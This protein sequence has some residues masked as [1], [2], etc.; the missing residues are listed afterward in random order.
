MHRGLNEQRCIKEVIT[1]IKENTLHRAMREAFACFRPERAFVP[2]AQLARLAVHLTSPPAALGIALAAAATTAGITLGQLSAFTTIAA[3]NT[4]AHARAVLTSTASGMGVSLKQ[5]SAATAA[6]TAAVA[7][8]LATAPGAPGA[9]APA[10]APVFDASQTTWARASA[11][12][13]AEMELDLLHEN[14]AAQAALDAD[15]K[16]KAAELNGLRALPSKKLRKDAVARM[17]ARK[18]KSRYVIEEKTQNLV[19]LEQARDDN[20]AWSEKSMHSKQARKGGGGV[21]LKNMVG[22]GGDDD[23]VDDDAHTIAKATIEGQAAAKLAVI[24]AGSSVNI[25]LCMVEA[26]TQTPIPIPNLIPIPTLTLTP[27]PAPTL[28]PT[29]PQP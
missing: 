13:A 5:L 16:A 17:F 9:P 19:A 28:S 2:I 15:E 26:R 11:K 25:K 10:P 24:D 4:P 22:A 23:D 29:Q 3:T 14:R 20:L 7:A 18:P 21:N 27:A 12:D 1:R 6:A 8:Y